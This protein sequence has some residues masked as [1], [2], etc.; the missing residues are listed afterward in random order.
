[1]KIE[2]DS[3]LMEKIGVDENEAIELLAIALYKY[4]GIHGSLAG[5]LIGKS[6]FD[7]HT[8]LSKNGESVNYDVDELIEDIKN[9]DL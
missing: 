6:E 1:M 8:I 4:K 3:S 5:K 7:F 9:N 2:I